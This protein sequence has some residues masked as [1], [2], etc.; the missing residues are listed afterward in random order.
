[1]NFIYCGRCWKFGDSLAVDAD[2]TK[3][4]F[5]SIRETRLEVLR[6][7][8]MCGIDP[9]FPK[10]VAPHDIVVAG[11]RFA[12]GNPHIQGLLGLKALE[13]GFVVESIP[14]GS[15]RNAIN[16]GVPFLTGCIGVTSECET[17]DELRV[18]FAT[19]VFENLTRN[20]R[21]VYQPL[22]PQLLDTIAIGGWQPMVM[23]RIAQLRDKGLIPRAAATT[24]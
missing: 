22:P 6:D 17:G 2:L 7:Y 13:L 9:D 5:A 15:F 21:I 14:R 4:E 1:M 10:K 11:R 19:G 12:Q 18:D 24:S 3:K 23:R 20:R 8:V 16:A